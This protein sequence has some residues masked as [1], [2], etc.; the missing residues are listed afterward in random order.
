MEE[1]KKKNTMNQTH[2][3]ETLTY[4]LPYLKC[5]FYEKKRLIVQPQSL[6]NVVF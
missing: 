4:L 2:I 6:I 3:L 5:L 1:T